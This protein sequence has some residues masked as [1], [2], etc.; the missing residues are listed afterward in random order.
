M[1]QGQAGVARPVDQHGSQIGLVAERVGPS[2]HR[3]AGAERETGQ[4]AGVHDRSDFV[5]ERVRIPAQRQQRDPLGIIQILIH[6]RFEPG[7]GQLPGDPGHVAAVGERKQ[8]HEQAFLGAL[9]LPAFEA[10]LLADVRRLEPG[11]LVRHR[12]SF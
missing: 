2:E 11:P 3:E 10:A 9:L 5:D 12:I 6:D 1:P 8:L 7:G 4:G